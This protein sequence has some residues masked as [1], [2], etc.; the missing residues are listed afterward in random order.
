MSIPL[1]EYFLTYFHDGFVETLSFQQ[2]VTHLFTEG[3]VPVPPGRPFAL[4]LCRITFSELSFQGGCRS[5]GGG[6]ITCRNPQKALRKIF[7]RISYE[8]GPD[9][10]GHKHTE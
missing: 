5:G 1:P 7:L 4:R 2:I 9:A 3:T 10:G 6:G 8:N